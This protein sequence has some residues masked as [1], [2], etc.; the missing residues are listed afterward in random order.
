MAG[1]ALGRHHVDAALAAA[2][3]ASI[4]AHERAAMLA[5]IATSLHRQA[6]SS[7]TLAW[8][9]ELYRRAA[10]L[11][12]G[13]ARRERASALARAAA[14]EIMAG[15]CD[16]EAL[17]AAHQ[18][19]TRARQDLE[20]AGDRLEAAHCD[21]NLGV[22]AQQ[23]A[24]RG[25][26][27]P[28][29]AVAAYQRALRV[30]GKAAHPCEYAVIQSNLATIYLQRRPSSPLHERLAVEALESALAALDRRRHPREWGMVQNN[31][32]NALQSIATEQPT[33]NLR[34]AIEAYDAALQVRTR[35]RAPLDYASTLANK[36]TC[37]SRLRDTPQADAGARV[38][39]VELAQRLYAEAAQVFAE[40]GDRERQHMLLDVIEDLDRAHA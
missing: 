2:D 9:T 30:F 4:A 35:E 19:L 26:L 33:E 21:M 14:A 6:L 37:L 25:A 29:E 12:P 27:A 28:G 40:A 34:R 20:V 39:A 18:T 31:L 5:D 11:F 16:T 24:E 22:V 36:A 3:D 17:F 10:T 13:D 38:S 1:P 7:Q 8:A 32:G 15:S 23:L